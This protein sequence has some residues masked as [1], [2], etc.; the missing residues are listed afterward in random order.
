[1][2][3][4]M[5]VEH[6]L[7][8]VKSCQQHQSYHQA[9]RD[10]WGKQVSRMVFFMGG[11]TGVVPSSDEVLLDCPDDYLSLP[12]KTK[13]ILEWAGDRFEY[14]Y[15]CDND[16]FIIPTRLMSLDYDR[17]DYSG[18]M[19]RHCPIGQTK[20]YRDHIGYYPNCH[21]WASGGVG[22]FL[23]KK[24]AQFIA[25]KTPD[26][27]AEDLWVGQVLGPEIQSGRMTAAHLPKLENYSAWHFKRTRKY[28]FYCPE[29]MYRSFRLGNPD[30]M[31]KEDND[32]SN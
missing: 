8:A 1:M 20:D 18:S 27:W 29:M 6:M 2:E 9:I 14:I 17:Y 3:L 10:T 15:L 25:K 22:Y 30:L 16:T 24:A 28:R 26:V 31:Y 11:L 21:P 19:D 5:A 13:K 23:S 12:L 4:V 32:N 7:I